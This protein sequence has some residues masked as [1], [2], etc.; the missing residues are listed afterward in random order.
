MTLGEIGLFA[1]IWVAAFAG[2]LAVAV[3]VVV[4]LPADYFTRPR[5]PFLGGA[6]PGVRAV[7]IV[8][9]NVAGVGIIAVGLVL[10]IPGVPGQGL[11]TILIG[12]L[13]VDFPGKFRLEKSIIRRPGVN[14]AVNGLRRRFGRPPLES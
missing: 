11:L 2:S 6:H 3:T 9:K 5:R 14:R 12:L 7:L 13:L 8:L 10:S 1:A 4:R